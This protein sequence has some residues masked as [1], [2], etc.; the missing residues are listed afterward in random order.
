[1]LCAVPDQDAARAEARRVL[2]PGGRFVFLEHVAAPS[3]TWLR[4]LQRGVRPVWRL[5]GD[6][7]FPDRETWH[8]IDRAGFREITLDRFHLPVPV[9]APHIGGWAVR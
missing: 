9:V 1:V 8:A 4:R 5:L 7:C 2:R 3:G 6:G